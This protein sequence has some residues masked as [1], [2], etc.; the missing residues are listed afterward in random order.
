MFVS[1]YVIY[2]DID[3]ND[4]LIASSLTGA[5]DLL[6]SKSKAAWLALA[7]SNKTDGLDKKLVACLAEFSAALF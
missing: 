4:A 1:K 7:A 5:V 2:Q 3:K 6:D